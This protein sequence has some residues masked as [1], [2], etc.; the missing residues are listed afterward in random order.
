MM[1]RADDGSLS[2]VDHRL[3]VWL[4]DD[5]DI[6]LFQVDQRF[7]LTFRAEQGKVDQNGIASDFY[8]CSSS[9]EGTDDPLFFA[10]HFKSRASFP[11][12]LKATGVRIRTGLMLLDIV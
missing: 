9:T 10:G 12:G 8:P 6:T 3:C 11:V 2:T 1:K 4:F 7:L 5:C